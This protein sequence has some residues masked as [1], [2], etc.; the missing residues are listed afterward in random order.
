MRGKLGG[1]VKEGAGKGLIPTHSGKTIEQ[2]DHIRHA[3]AYPH[4]RGENT[5]V[6][7]PWCYAEG[8]SPLMRGKPSG[9]LALAA[10][11]RLIPAHAGKTAHSGIAPYPPRL[12]PA[13]AGKTQTG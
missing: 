9:V 13:H 8:S 12:I 5:Y 10:G 1:A 7:T 6:V 4:S 11:V 2:Y 3:E